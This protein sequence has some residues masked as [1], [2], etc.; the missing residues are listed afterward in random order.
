MASCSEP[1]QILCVPTM[2]GARPNDN[3]LLIP[4]CPQDI[5]QTC[6][7]PSH[8]YLSNLICRHSLIF[9]IALRSSPHFSDSTLCN[10]VQGPRKPIPYFLPSK[11]QAQM[12][13]SDTFSYSF[14]QLFGVI[15]LIFPQSLIHHGYRA[16]SMLFLFESST[17]SKVLDLQQQISIKGFGA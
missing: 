1:C 16:A 11:N 12:P 8:I 6:Q 3:K 9:L 2:H 13:L 15:S 4:W 17:S 5:C 10:S 7:H 14:E